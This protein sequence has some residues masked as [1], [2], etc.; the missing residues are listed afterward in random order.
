MVV[1][2]PKSSSFDGSKAEQLHCLAFLHSRLQI[3][4]QPS[5]NHLDSATAL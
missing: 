1:S 3:P 2:L 4:R 5:T